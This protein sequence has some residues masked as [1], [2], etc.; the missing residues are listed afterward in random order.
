VPGH[1]DIAENKIANS[2]AKEATKLD[3]LK[4]KTS[5]VVLGLKIKALDS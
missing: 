3:S 5:F 4:N 2:L 1:I